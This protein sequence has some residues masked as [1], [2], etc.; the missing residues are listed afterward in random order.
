MIRKDLMEEVILRWVLEFIYPTF[1]QRQDLGR[2]QILAS[3]EYCIQKLPTWTNPLHIPLCYFSST[4]DSLHGQAK[5]STSQL[6][7]FQALNL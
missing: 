3:T 4:K 1:S 2:R 5:I 7:I 6:Y